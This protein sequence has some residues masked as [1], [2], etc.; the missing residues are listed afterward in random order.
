MAHELDFQSVLSSPLSAKSLFLGRVTDRAVSLFPILSIKRM[1]LFAMGF[2]RVQI[3]NGGAILH[4][5]LVWREQAEML[6]VN[7]IG[8][9]ASVVHDHSIRDFTVPSVPSNA[10]GSAVLTP[11]VETSVSV[12]VQRPLPKPTAGWRKDFSLGLKS[13]KLFVGKV[14]GSLLMARKGKWTNQECQYALG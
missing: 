9:A 4:S 1:T 5:I 11:K 2:L 12:F 3:R 13:V 10:M 14:H 6:R 7:A 8:S